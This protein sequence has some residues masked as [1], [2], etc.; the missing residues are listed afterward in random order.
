MTDDRT[1]GA[2]KPSRGGS[3]AVS[4][5]RVGRHKGVSERVEGSGLGRKCHEDRG[6][7]ALSVSGIKGGAKCP[8]GMRGSDLRVALSAES[9]NL[10]P[11]RLRV[12]LSP[13]RSG[14]GRNPG[15]FRVALSA[16][17]INQT[18][19]KPQAETPKRPA[20]ATKVA[21][22][23]SDP[24]V[25]DVDS[26]VKFK[27]YFG[28]ENLGFEPKEDPPKEFKQYSG[29]EVAKNGRTKVRKM[30][31]L[32]ED[33]TLRPGVPVRTQGQGTDCNV[34][35]HAFPT[36]GYSSPEHIGR[37]GEVDPWAWARKAR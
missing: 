26:P 15:E 16:E 5:V 35:K 13:E 9:I 6:A 32:Q 29:G 14:P 18:Q 37:V 21:Y 33:W 17:S 3:L 23:A 34:R 12:G 1:C 31:Q 7:S 24:S 11:K 22:G 25:E 30:L 19:T 36:Y 27:Q 8:G 28:S 20:R 4:D 2:E 10:K